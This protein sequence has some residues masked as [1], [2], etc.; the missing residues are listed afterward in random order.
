MDGHEMINERDIAQASM[1]RVNLEG[2]AW[3]G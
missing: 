3:G 1:F 2:G